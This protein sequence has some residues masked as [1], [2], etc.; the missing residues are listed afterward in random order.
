M[1]FNL[2]IR[3]R[4]WSS[5]TCFSGKATNSTVDPTTSHEFSN[6]PVKEPTSVVDDLVS[7][8]PP[9]TNADNLFAISRR[10]TSTVE[11]Q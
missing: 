7:G 11:E 5:S 1:I 10:L 6:E 3:M 4:Y 8:V 9:V 2:T